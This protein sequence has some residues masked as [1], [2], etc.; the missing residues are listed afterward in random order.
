MPPQCYPGEESQD[1]AGLFVY[2]RCICPL[3]LLFPSDPDDK[4]SLSLRW[5]RDVSERR[6]RKSL[7]SDGGRSE[8]GPAGD[9]R[10]EW[11]GTGGR[12]GGGHKK[13]VCGRCASF[14]RRICQLGLA[15]FALGRLFELTCWR[16]SCPTDMALRSFLLLLCKIG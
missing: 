6:P 10:R 1:P 14:G 9:E 5:G 16:L 11:N 3:R 2:M 13:P 8:E 15:L 12:G 4:Q 7:S